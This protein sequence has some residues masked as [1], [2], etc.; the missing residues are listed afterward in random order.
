MA[1][2]ASQTLSTNTSFLHAS[3]HLSNP[4][5][6]SQMPRPSWYAFKHTTFEFMWSQRFIALYRILTLE[7]FICRIGPPLRFYYLVCNDVLLSPSDTSRMCTYLE[8]D[9]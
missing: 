1:W 6:T 9:L 3:W 4:P 5:L 8:D 2:W 7:I